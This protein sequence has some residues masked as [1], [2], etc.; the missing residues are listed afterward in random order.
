MVSWP[1]CVPLQDW[2]VF[3]HHWT[4]RSSSKQFPKAAIP[5]WREVPVSLL[6]AAIITAA[7]STSLIYQYDGKQLLR[8]QPIG[9]LRPA[10]MGW[11]FLS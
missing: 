11:L 3:E 7:S 5:S 6:V 1:L 2:L 4:E 10:S 8:S 9:R